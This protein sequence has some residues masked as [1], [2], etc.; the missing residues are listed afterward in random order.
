ME[1]RIRSYLFRISL[2]LGIVLIVVG[3]YF[4]WA[5]INPRHTGPVIDLHV[6]MTDF[7]LAIIEFVILVPSIFSLITIHQT[8]HITGVLRNG[9]YIF[10]FL[11]GLFYLLL[12]MYYLIDIHDPYV[13]AAGTYMVSIGGLIFTLCATAQLLNPN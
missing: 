11:T 13:A 5:K 9:A 1:E 10:T 6:P 4:P 2:Y 12:P 3:L 7:G 8:S